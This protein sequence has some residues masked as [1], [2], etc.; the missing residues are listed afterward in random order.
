MPLRCHR[1]RRES[2][3]L[4]PHGCMNTSIPD[5]PHTDPNKRYGFNWVVYKF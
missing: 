2:P 5:V 4:Q 1:G 3:E